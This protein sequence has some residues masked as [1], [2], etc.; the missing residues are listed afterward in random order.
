[1]VEN[2]IPIIPASRVKNIVL[3]EGGNL[4]E[5]T[6]QPEESQR[7]HT[8]RGRWVIDAMGRRRFLQKKLGIAEP[9]N[10]HFSAAWFRLKGRIDVSK[11]VPPEETQWHERVHNDARYYSTNHLMDNGRWVWLI[12]LATNSTSIGIVAHEGF[13]PFAE[14]NTYER[15]LQWLRKYEPALMDMIAPVVDDPI[16]F[17]CMRHYSYDATRVFSFQRWACTGDA[18]AFSDPFVSP[19]IDQLGFANTCITDLIKRD[20][21]GTLREPTVDAFNER[22]L[23][24]NSGVSLLTHIGYPFFGKSLVMGTKLFWDFTIGFA[25]NG[26][27]RFNRLYIDEQKMEALQPL[28]SVI[29]LLTTRMEQFFKEWGERSSGNYSYEFFDYLAAPGMREI[30]SR[31]LQAHKTLDELLTDYQFTLDYLEELAQVIFLIALID[32]MPAMLGHLPSPL[33]LNAWVIGLDARKWRAEKL[34]A[35]SSKRRPLKLAE[36]TTLFGVPQLWLKE[37]V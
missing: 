36:F 16:D 30:Y 8:V 15:A 32:T 25:V 31:N 5:I 12:P 11:L 2:G 24:F 3:A 29:Y 9:A 19:G 26:P 20:R 18:A 22:F 13:F 10:P 27:Q 6:F 1:N 4:H 33:W 17:Q 14:Y 23:N 21:A 7:S 28:L 35:P 37:L 34:F